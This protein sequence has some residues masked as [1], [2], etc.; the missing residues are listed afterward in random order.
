MGLQEAVTQSSLNKPS[1][2]A[3]PSIQVQQDISTT[4]NAINVAIS[5]TITANNYNQILSR[6]FNAQ[7]GTLNL[8][9]TTITNS[10]ILQS[11]KI[12]S[13]IIA[14]S[15]ITS[16]I[17]ATNTYLGSQNSNVTVSQTSTNTSKGPLDFLQSGPGISCMIACVICCCLLIVL[18]LF[19]M[20]KSSNVAVV[21][22]NKMPPVPP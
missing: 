11:Q 14:Q 22:M 9:N 20:Q 2:L 6:T 7:T 5:Q 13:T 16:V 12:V 3:P 19:A 18:L 4:R 21:G 10:T 15:L 8:S 1:F 17:N